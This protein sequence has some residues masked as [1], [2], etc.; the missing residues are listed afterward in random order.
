M[1]NQL[2]K[3][4][5]DKHFSQAISSDGQP[6]WN[7]VGRVC[8]Q[9]WMMSKSEVAE[10][11]DLDAHPDSKPFLSLC[12]WKKENDRAG[13]GLRVTQVHGRHSLE[14][15]FSNRPMARPH[16]QNGRGRH[17]IPIFSNGCG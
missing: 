4:C 12:P 17:L 6:T 8:T 10:M 14:H 5:F 1:F 7:T 3:R 9:V 15:G 2:P 16:L 11:C 13:K